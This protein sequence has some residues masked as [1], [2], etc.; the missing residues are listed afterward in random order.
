ML[1]LVGLSLCGLSAGKV[2]KPF[3]NWLCDYCALGLYILPILI[4]KKNIY[5]E[6]PQLDPD[7]CG[8]PIFCLF[9]LLLLLIFLVT[10]YTTMCKK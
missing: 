4:G 9:Y 3:T 7:D 2:I 8:A 1:V 10:A 5:I 6:G